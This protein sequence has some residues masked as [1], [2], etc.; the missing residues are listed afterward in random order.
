MTLHIFQNYKEALLEK[1]KSPENKLA[2]QSYF[3]IGFRTISRQGLC[4]CGKKC[5]KALLGQ[6]DPEF[7]ESYLLERRN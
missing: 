3:F 4:R 7:T 1:N 6:I 5:L 2:Y